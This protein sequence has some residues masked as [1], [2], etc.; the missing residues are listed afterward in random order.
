[1]ELKLIKANDIEY[2]KS[3]LKELHLTNDEWLG[4]EE[5]MAF[6]RVSKRTM[7]RYRMAGKIPFSKNERKIYFKK[8]DLQRFLEGYYHEIC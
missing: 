5:A 2:I 7:F 3:E 8:S 1:M 6:L 4:N